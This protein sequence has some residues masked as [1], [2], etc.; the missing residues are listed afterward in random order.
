MSESFSTKPKVTSFEVAQKAGVSRS[1]VSRTF[2]D[3]AS[4]SKETREKVIAAARDLGYRV[5]ALAR[6][7]NRRRSDLV[8]V[9]AADMDNPFRAEQVDYLSRLLLQQG[10]RPILLRGDPSADVSAII[11]QLLQY[12]VAGVIVTSDTPPQQ[13]CD[14][15]H[16]CGVPLVTINKQ[17]PGSPVDRVQCDFEMGG[18]L[19]YEHLRTQGCERLALVTPETASF[20]VAGRGKAFLAHCKGGGIPVEVF[21]QGRQHYDAG[22]TV[23]AQV[24]DRWNDLDG[25][26]CTGDYMALG[27]LDGLRQDHG[28]RV[29]ED[30]RLIGFDDIQQAAWAAYDLTTIRQSRQDL[31]AMAVELLVRRIDD[32]LL[33]PQVQI[34]PVEL[35]VRK[36]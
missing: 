35:V 31:S 28:L 22:R 8:G 29:P 32:P 26:F 16:A 11:G 21:K 17:D 34:L 9:V 33:A 4:V 24:A 25:V 19:A 18:R 12:S 2:T 20:T 7:L 3:G 1:A 6:S 14:E 23:A 10:F 27:L 5:N 15:C 30:L 36:T 13:I